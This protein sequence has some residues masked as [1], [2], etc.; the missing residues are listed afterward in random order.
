[1]VGRDAGLDSVMAES[2][3][4]T[5]S[6]LAQKGRIIMT[7]MHCPSSNIMSRVTHILLLTHDGRLA[8]HGPKDSVTAHFIAQG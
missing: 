5:L 4:A 8:Y 6:E 2:V 7:S 3:V 1:V